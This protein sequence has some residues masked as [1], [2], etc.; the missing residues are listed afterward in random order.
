MF[1]GVITFK[2]LFIGKTS[3]FYCLAFTCNDLR[4]LYGIS[5]LFNQQKIIF[6]KKKLIEWLNFYCSLLLSNPCLVV[7]IQ[8]IITFI[9]NEQKHV[10]G[11]IFMI[12]NKRIRTCYIYI[13]LRIKKLKLISIWLAILRAI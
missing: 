12:S 4:M 7:Y 13:P 5:F 11:G 2:I 3:S 1:V 6:F 8:H 9:Y 10:A